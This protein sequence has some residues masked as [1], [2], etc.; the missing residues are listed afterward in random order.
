MSDRSEAPLPSARDLYMGSGEAVLVHDPEDGTVLD[1]NPTAERLYGHDTS[2]LRGRQVSEL[3]AGERT[4][5]MDV[6]TVADEDRDVRWHVEH[7]DDERRWLDVSLRRAPTN[8]YILS[9]GRDI[10][11]EQIQQRALDQREQALETAVDGMAIVDSDLRFVHVNAP[12]AS[13]HGYETPEELIGTDWEQLYENSEWS[14]LTD[15]MLPAVE[16]QGEWRG[17]T[18]GRRT[19]GTSFPK[20]VSV[21]RLDDESYVLV[22]RD[23]SDLCDRERNLRENQQTLRRLQEIVSQRDVEFREKVRQLLKLGREWLGLTVG[24]MTRI[25]DGTQTIDS[26]VGDHDTIQP[27]ESAPLAETYC[28]HTLDSGETIYSITD[29]TETEIFDSREYERFGL[30]CYLGGKI[31]VDGADYGTLCFAD[32]DPRE[33]PFTGMEQTFVELITQWVGL[34]IER[35]RQA[36]QLQEE[37]ELTETILAS[38]P[39]GVLVFGDNGQITLANDRAAELVGDRAKLDTGHGLPITLYDDE[40]QEIPAAEMPQQRV[41]QGESL[42]NAKYRLEDS[43]GPRYISV[44][45]RPLKTGDRS[46]VVLTVADITERHRHTD[47]MRALSNRLASASGSFET[48]LSSLLDIGRTHLGLSNGHLTEIDGD[49]H[50]IIVSEG[51]P[52]QLPVGVV[53]DLET[54]F[55][56]SVVDRSGMCSIVEASR[57]RPDATPSQKWG[58]ETYI[59][60]TVTVNGEMYGTICFVDEEP[61]E[62]EFEPWE[63]TFVET[64]GQWVETQIR[65][66]QNSEE[67]DRDRALL[68]GVFN[69]QRTQ[70]GILDTDGRVIDANEAAISFIDSSPEE[71]VGAQI[72]ETPWF[73]DDRAYERC[74]RGVELASQ[75]EMT[76]FEV[77]YTGPDRAETEFSVNIRPVVEAGEVINIIVEGHDVTELRRREREL[78]RRQTH[79]D[80]ILNNVPL[81]LFGLNSDGEFLHSRGR[82]LAAFGLED[83]EL[84][85]RSIYEEYGS[86]PGVIDDYERARDGEAVESV[87]TIGETAFRSWYRPVEIE[88]ETQVIGISFD[89]TTQQRQ[90]QRV[91]AVHEATEKFMYARSPKEVADCV[92]GIVGELLP[93]PLA[94]VW[95]PD[96]EEEAVLTPVAA[97]EEMLDCVDEATVSE[98]LSTIEPGTLEMEAFRDGS[99]R[100]IEDYQAS[101]GEIGGDTPIGTVVLVPLG[102]Y[103]TLHLGSLERNLPTDTELDL[104]GILARNA[105]AALVST[106][107]EAELKAYKNELERSNEA[108]QQFA[109]V[110]SHD[111]QEPLRMVSSYV[112][113]L[114]SEYGEELGEEATEYME[115][116]V[117]GAHRMQ[118]MVDA[119]L[120]YSRV[121]TQAGEFETIDPNAVVEET[122]DALRIRIAETDASVS[123]AQ[124]PPVKADANQLGQLF[125][126]LLKNAIE[127]AHEN[128][129]DPHVEIDGTI[130][131]DMVTVSVSDNGPGIEESAQSNVFEIFTRGGTHTTEGTGIGLAVCQRIVRR[132]GGRIWVESTDGDGATFNFTL[133]AA[134]EEQS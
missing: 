68:E 52:A 108:L 88:G 11:T 92:V 76:N 60:T 43:D 123:A 105:E 95:V 64:L 109:Y 44:S 17:E 36:E 27:G 73:T 97:T 90:K 42:T 65:Q 40:G 30:S 127:Y 70:I 87:R 86:F 35:Q 63:R 41:A 77:A 15:R 46:G 80:T 132:H 6:T 8:E 71:I 32:A 103:G 39:T 69:S 47:A 59:G 49:R 24:Y 106:T 91:S 99:T 29:A 37:H 10:T 50:E 53:S 124:L 120:K 129:A 113:L 85:G 19:S 56:Q 28:Q 74:K 93:Y 23:I 98:G 62:Q 34:T 89:I 31:T 112:D 45:G 9:F 104:I 94:G 20:A 81:V 5:E 61:R 133:P 72:W 117:D 78:E 122:L 57:E 102:D 51:L 107:R 96:E 82:A 14:G 125:Q 54:T 115:F 79:I 12:Y 75:G 111:L 25:D 121:E 26:A 110:A 67:R 3:L 48:Q 22:A 55:C 119:L 33:E 114:A 101:D 130:S 16:Q 126:N 1:A 21:K 128:G 38:S 66:Q 134:T 4:E 7:T 83:D 58:L 118:D 2:A 13:L 116:A 131:D 18:I 100:V 84:V